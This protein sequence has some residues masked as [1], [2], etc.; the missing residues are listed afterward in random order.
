VSDPG[1]EPISPR[2]VLIVGSYPPIPVA[3]APAT[4]RE[5]RRAWAAGDEVTVVSPRISAAHLA[6]PVFGLLAGRRLDNVRRHTGAHRLVL[7]VEPGFP[8]PDSPVLQAATAAALVVALRR[9]EHVRLVRVGAVPM[10]AAVWKRLAGAADEVVAETPGPPVPGVTVPGVTVLGP[11]EVAWSERPAQIFGL[12]A[13][14]VLGS[15]A[16]AVRGRLGRVR[17]ALRARF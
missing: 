10:P 6:V 12:V 11:P 8:F 17:R 3:G 7:V 14:R 5:V 2:R 13:R 15:Q 16:P 4:V 9:F 1:S